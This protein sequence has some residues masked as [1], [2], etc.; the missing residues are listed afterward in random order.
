MPLLG[1]AAMLLTFDIEKAAIGE[2]DDW[3]THEHLPERLAIPGFLR[4]TRWVSVRGSPRYAV[5]YEVERLE[6]LESEAYLER[7]NNP[8]PWTSKMMTHYRGMIRGLCSVERSHGLGAGYYLLLVRFKP[9][10]DSAALI[11]W[12]DDVLPHL[13]SRPGLGSVHLLRGALA[14]TMTSEQQLRGV[15]LGADWALMATGYEPEAVAELESA[16]LSLRELHAHGCASAS[17][18]LYRAAYSLSAGE[19]GSRRTTFNHAD[20]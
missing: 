5:I 4:G 8:T 18:A 16:E 6:T 11:N 19:I 14:A 15:D 1:K 17:L 3:H 10:A 2:H 9:P 20:D 7:L 12:L 13:P